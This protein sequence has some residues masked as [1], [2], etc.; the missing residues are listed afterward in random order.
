MKTYTAPLRIV[1]FPY[2]A[3]NAFTPEERAK[4]NARIYSD[5]LKKVRTHLSEDISRAEV[6][7]EEIC[8]H[9]HRSLDAT[10][11]GYPYC[12]QRAQEDWGEEHPD[13]DP[14]T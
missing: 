1:L 13:E 2:E 7:I 8:G 9:C 10:A 14:K 3:S 4:A 6:V 11:N 5:V 12:C